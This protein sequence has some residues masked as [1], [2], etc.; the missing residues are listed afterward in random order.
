M[1]PF[2]PPPFPLAHKPPKRAPVAVLVPPQDGRRVLLLERDL[3]QPDRIVG[4]LL[5]PGGYLMLKKLGLADATDEIDAQK[6]G[7]G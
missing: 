4:E 6:V 3:T 1:H 2:R 7:G 5:Q